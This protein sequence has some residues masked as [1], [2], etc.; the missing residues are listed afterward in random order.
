MKLGQ[1]KKQNSWKIILLCILIGFILA[2]SAAYYIVSDLKKSSDSIAVRYEKNISNI[3]NTVYES[4]Y[5]DY[6]E[7]PFDFMAENN[8]ESID[9]YLHLKDLP[10]QIFIS[11]KDSVENK[12]VYQSRVEAASDTDIIQ[13]SERTYALIGVSENKYYNM[14]M[15]MSV[16][17]I[18]NKPY[19]SAQLHMDIIHPSKIDLSQY[20]KLP[21]YIKNSMVVPGEGSLISCDSTFGSDRF[22]AE[23]MSDDATFHFSSPQGYSYVQLYSADETAEYTVEIWQKTSESGSDIKLATYEVRGTNICMPVWL[24]EKESYIRVIRKDSGEPNA[25]AVAVF[26]NHFPQ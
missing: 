3:A 10:M 23:S 15:E 20:A 4:K 25:Y 7:Y 26:V 19:I 11:E 18:D 12:L 24:A 17:P 14:D 13:I 6:S 5:V 22:Y 8:G 16:S 21:K 2:A 1:D 9:F